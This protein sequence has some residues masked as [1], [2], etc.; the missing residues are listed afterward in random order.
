MDQISSQRFWPLIP[1]SEQENR[2]N[3]HHVFHP[4]II[5]TLQ[6]QE[7]HIYQNCL[8]HPPQQSRDPSHPHHSQRKPARLCR[9][10]HHT[11]SNHHNSEVSI[12]QC[13]VHPSS[14]VCLGRYKK[15][16]PQK[17]SPRSRVHGVPHSNYTTVDHQRV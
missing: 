12:Q 13:S 10:T 15:L 5:I 8:R 17:C 3:Q 7:S 1:G 11:N 4:K 6:N 16:F 2:G 14:K 9:N